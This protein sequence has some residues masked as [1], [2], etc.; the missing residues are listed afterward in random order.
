MKKLFEHK[1]DFNH[2]LAIK[3]YMCSFTLVLLQIPQIKEFIFSVN[4]QWYLGILVISYIYCLNR[5][6]KS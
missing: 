1:A 6:I 2:K 5:V 4:W 3:I